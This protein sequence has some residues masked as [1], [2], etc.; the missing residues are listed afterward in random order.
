MMAQN[1]AWVKVEGLHIL[2]FALKI[3]NR[4]FNLDKHL[5]FVY[6]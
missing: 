5:F 6:K 3:K 1:M 4:A 2:H